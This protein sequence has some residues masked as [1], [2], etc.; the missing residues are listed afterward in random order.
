MELKE[1]IFKRK[2]I[3]KYLNKDLEPSLINEILEFIKDI[4]PLYEDIKVKFDIVNK[5]NVK[6]M[7]SWLSNQMIVVYSEKKDGY[8]ENVGFMMQQLDL[9]LQ[10]KG[11]GSCWI[12]I[13]KIDE[14]VRS[15]NEELEYVI[16]MC[17]GYHEEEY[18]NGAKDFKRYALSE[19]S[20]VLDERLEVARLAPSSI[21]NQPWYFVH[22]GNVI[23][24]YV[25]IRNLFKKR[26][27][28][29]LLLIDV[30]IAL[31]HIYVSYSKFEYFKVENIEEKKGFNY[32]G[33]FIIG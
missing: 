9:F 26:M 16:M 18:R 8:N 10:S 6:S 5:E 25:A 15:E 33:S 13:G 23:H 19:I 28:E 20:D 31:S 1:V 27:L 30:G 7:F 14:G 32:L 2:S 3:R 11:L 21:N 24:T 17:V 12:G 4:K 29:N 22:D